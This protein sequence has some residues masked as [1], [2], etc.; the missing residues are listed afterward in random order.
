VVYVGS[1]CT[2]SNNLGHSAG[3]DASYASTAD[4]VFANEGTHDYTLQVTSPA[5][6]LGR[7]ITTVTSASGSGTSFDVDD[8]SCLCDGF[9]IAEGDLIKVGSNS[10]VRITDI[11]GS[12]VTVAASQTWIVGDSVYWRNQDATVDAGAYEYRAA[13]YGVNL[14]LNLI[15]GQGINPISQTITPA[16]TTPELVRFVE[17]FIDGIPVSIDYDSPYSYVWDTSGLVV[18][19]THKVVVR[20]Y[21]LYASVTMYE[22]IDVDVGVGAG[23]ANPWVMVYG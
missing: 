13:G 12:T 6:G 20:A 23:T 18:G 15:D 8:V 14:T 5:I 3:A 7:A 11:T 2:K 10:Q 1:V 22:E 4:P 19:S 21:H 9:G 17:I 16:S